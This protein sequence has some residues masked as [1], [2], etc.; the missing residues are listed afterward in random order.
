[1]VAVL[2]AAASAVLFLPTT[3]AFAAS[4][5]VVI[6]Q[7]YGGGGNS[8][9][10]Y[11]NDF[12]ELYNRSSGTVSLSGWTVQYASATGSSWQKTAL[13]GTLA[14]GAHYLVQ[15]AAGTSGGAA[16]PTADATGAINLSATSGKVAL[17]TN[18][19]ALTCA[20]GC[21][22]S[23]GVWDFVGYGSTASSAEGSPTPNLSN[24]TAALRAG[25]GATDT[26][27]NAADFTIGAPNPRNTS[28]G[29]GSGTR[30]HDIQG[31][32]HVSPLS[33]K[34]VTGVPGV[35]TAKDGTGFWVQDPQ[36]DADPATSEGIYVYTSAAPTV[37]VA[38]SVTVSG[39]VSEFRPG[40]SGGA[41]NLTTTEITSP[42][43]TTV[44]HG[45][46]MP[47][48]TVVGPGGRV[49]P[50][51]VIED[52]AT[53][54][55]ETSGAFD[56][57]SDGIDFWESL[58]GMRVELD[59]A[60]VVG[61]RTS[62]GEI[63][64]VPQGSATRTNRGGIVLRSGDPNPE[65]VIVDDALAAT[66]TANVGDTLA[67]A[68]VG[69]LGYSFGDFKLE[70]TSAPT[71]RGGGL[72]RESTTPATSGQLA[73]ATFNVE[74]LAPS[75]PQ[76]KFDRLAA[77][78][79]ANLAAPDLIAVEEIQDNSGATDDGT[80]AAD[81]TLG[82]LTSAID[83][84][85][86][87]AYAWREIDPVNDADGGQPGGNI[88]QVFLFRTDRGLSFVDRPGGAST[89]ATAVTNTGGVPALSYSPGR[90]DPT[91]GA[92][93]ASRKP[94]AG[95]FRWNGRTVFAIANHFNSKGG[96]QPLFGHF[97]PPSRPSETQRHQQASVVRGFVD[98]ILAVDPNAAVVVLGDLNDFEF[99]QTTDILTAGGALVDLP[100][101]LPLAERYTYDYEGN[102]EVLD[103]V[104]LST[105]LAGTGYGYDVVHVNSEFADQVSDHEPQVV[106]LPLP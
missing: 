72:A 81:V 64:V 105:S 97:Q 41:T 75:D 67:G 106:R 54:D 44:A 95:E 33:G 77:T 55:V 22:T 40:G 98:Q 47:A 19:T 28:S 32:S 100:R 11:G 2:A 13:S 26:D 51:T 59:D 31:T 94:L 76:S 85:G 89:A 35:V 68:T 99:S 38:D 102:S 30:I 66:P 73:A 5:D 8:G 91:N 20:T 74:N 62:F 93:T 50:G 4:P 96:D 86:G 53:G 23:A 6:S 1:V 21:A 56:P 57:A 84:A 17:V 52:D 70:V 78:I 14:A 103:H 43:V 79:V 65:R 34:S 69:V 45:V 48:P 88:R 10:P 29:G 87:P 92:F 36:P 82:K 71:V 60:A 3:S 37:A 24:T 18:G 83:A 58:E 12:V 49:P 90:I 7:V 16:L 25:G 61:P 15:E 104:L 46:A 39:T 9:A 101:T 42:T 27:N 80:V 63:P